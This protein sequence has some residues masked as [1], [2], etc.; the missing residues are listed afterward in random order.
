M[1]LKNLKLKEKDDVA[2]LIDQYAS[3]NLYHK[4]MEIYCQKLLQNG[5]PIEIFIDVDDSKKLD[6]KYVEILKAAVD[7]AIVFE[8]TGNEK[9][10]I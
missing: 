6:E 1:I 9:T 5:L 7:E 10:V 4:I 8:G 2:V 3:G